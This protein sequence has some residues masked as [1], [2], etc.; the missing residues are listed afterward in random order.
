MAVLAAV[1]TSSPFLIPIDLREINSASVPLLTAIPYFELY[2]FL[3]LY[4]KFFNSSP[5]KYYLY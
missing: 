2:F 1:I 4:S 3:K 5:K